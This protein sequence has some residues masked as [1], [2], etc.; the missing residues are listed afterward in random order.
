[1]ALDGGVDDGRLVNADDWLDV[2]GDGG[3]W[4]SC[5]NELLRNDE[6]CVDLDWVGW[7]GGGGPQNDDDDDDTDEEDD[8]DAD[9]KVAEKDDAED[10]VTGVV[11][12]R[13]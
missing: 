3:L 10:D 8:E 7:L 2:L 11:S 12:G 5:E 13:P 6:P 1:M 9:D 4:W